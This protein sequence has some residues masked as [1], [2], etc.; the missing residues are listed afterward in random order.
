[1]EQVP[2]LHQ[3][4]A[5]VAL[6]ASPFDDRGLDVEPLL[7][8]PRLVALAASDPLATRID[9]SLADL[10]GRTLP[11][12]APADRDGLASP[13]ETPRRGLDLAQIFNLIEVGDNIWF[14]PA[15]IARRH[16]RPGIAYRPV[17]DLKPTTLAV[18]WPQNC[19]SPA[20]AAFVCA[21]TSIAAVTYPA[22]LMASG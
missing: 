14:P 5:D 6:L 11:D 10:A 15:S 13:P 2:A 22:G 4:R 17:T 18:A 19:H 16:P 8:E 7:T 1:M 3:G 9:L 21:A 12:G 20:V